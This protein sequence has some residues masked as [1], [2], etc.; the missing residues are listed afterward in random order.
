MDVIGDST[1]NMKRVTAQRRQKPDGGKQP[2]LLHA[3]NGTSHI[4]LDEV[5]AGSVVKAP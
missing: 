2:H 1:H 5:D 4:K 3:G